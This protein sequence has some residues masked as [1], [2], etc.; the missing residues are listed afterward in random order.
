MALVG[1]APYLGDFPAGASLNIYF[2]TKTDAGGRVEP[3]S[4]FE[5]ADLRIYKNGSDAQRTGVSGLTMTSPFDSLVGVQLLTIELS[6]NDDAGFYASGN[7]YTV[8]L[9][10]DE[11]VETQSISE[12]LCQFSIDNRSGARV[13]PSGGHGA[14]VCTPPKASPNGFVIAFGENEVNDEDS[15]HAL[16][17]T[18]HD[19][20]AQNDGGTEKI[21][22]YYEFA[23]GGDG[24][25]TSASWMGYLDKGGGAAKNITVQAYNWETSSWNVVGTIRSTNSNTDETFMLFTVHVG[26]GDDS[27]L[28][29]IRFVT[30]SPAFSATTTL[31][32]DQIVAAYT[33]VSRTAGYAN[34]AIWVDTNGSNT[35]TESFVDGTA[36]NPVST[37]AA[38]LTLSGQLGMT[39]F[40]IAVGSSITLTGNSD[41]YTLIGC[42]WTLALGGQS[43][44][45][46]FF[47]GAKVTGTGTGSGSTFKDCELD[48]GAATNFTVPGGTFLGCA[49][50]GHLTCSARE[51]NY[52]EGCYSGVAGTDTPS[53]DFGAAAGNTALNFRHYSGGIEIKN[54]EA[55]DLMSLE[56]EGQLVIN[57]SCTGGM[58]AVRGLFTVTDNASGAVTLSDDARV[59]GAAV[60]ITEVGGVT[61]TKPELITHTRS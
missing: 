5:A 25:P 32:T 26:T 57:A 14:A 51:T 28:V 37:W 59:P 21:D 12:V 35:N 9:Y 4:A 19:I 16:D 39:K 53:I 30:G 40:D 10:P 8:V 56:G 1:T 61:V 3:N 49:I 47:E 42:D 44:A 33:I 31:K 52:F 24:I 48:T 2:T 43:I 18:Y 46:A 41:N 58:V 7:D 13:N 20:Q 11:T 45:S 6:D 15:T 27:G 55:G 50:A 17:G 54:M 36:D 23:I 60:N 34:G 22:V 38:A 29:R